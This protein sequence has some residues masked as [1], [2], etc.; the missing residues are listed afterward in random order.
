M[1]NWLQECPATRMRSIRCCRGGGTPSLSLGV[2]TK[3]CSDVM[4]RSNI[5]VT[6]L[7]RNQQ[8]RQHER[9]LRR[10]RVQLWSPHDILLCRLSRTRYPEILFEHCPE[11][12]YNAF[13][14]KP[15]IMT[16][17]HRGPSRG[18]P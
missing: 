9:N 18:V 17:I 11:V 3:G 7:C 1:E 13:I 15:A 12:S 4:P 10:G 14:R 16:S 6:P 5:R 2:S 8:R